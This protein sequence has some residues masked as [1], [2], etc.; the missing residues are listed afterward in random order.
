MTITQKR[1]FEVTIPE[2]LNNLMS[3]SEHTI[4][5]L[6][7]MQLEL[8]AFGNEIGDALG[9]FTPKP[10]ANFVASSKQT[11]G[12]TM[13]TPEQKN[14]IFAL[15]KEKPMT[16][17]EIVEATDLPPQTIYNIMHSLYQAKLVTRTQKTDAKNYQFIFALPPSDINVL[18]HMATVE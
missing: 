15:L 13:G 4:S 2:K 16:S 11:V 12:K 5:S 1:V 10:S 9:S 14:Q 18:D 7:D 17:R 6:R 3:L 8:V